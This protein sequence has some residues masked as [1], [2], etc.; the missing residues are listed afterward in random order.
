[1]LY[2]ELNELL[3]HMETKG[4]KPHKKTLKQEILCEEQEL[5]GFESALNGGALSDN[6]SIYLS[7]A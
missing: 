7:A 1:V 3:G 5:P 2:Q 6:L 4:T